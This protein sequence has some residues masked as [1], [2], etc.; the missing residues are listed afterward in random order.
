MISDSSSYIDHSEIY[1]DDQRKC[2]EYVQKENT[3]ITEQNMNL[4]KQIK[5]LKDQFDRAVDSGSDIDS[6]VE[7]NKKI[8]SENEKL[9]SEKQDFAQRLKILINTNEQITQEYKL[10]LSESQESIEILKQRYEAQIQKLK[11]KNVFN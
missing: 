5:V 10:K 8:R 2:I 1:S 7:E 6:L 11:L 3:E 4:T 9:Q